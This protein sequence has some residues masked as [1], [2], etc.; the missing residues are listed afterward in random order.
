MNQS[1]SNKARLRGVL[2]PVVTPFNPDFG[3]D[4]GLFIA[5]CKALVADG[6]GLAVF[7]TNSE[8][9]SISPCERMAAL[10]QLLQAGIPADRLMPG[11]GCCSIEETVALTSHA[12]SLGVRSVL[13]LPPF[14]YKEVDQAG[15]LQY[16]GTVIDR[17]GGAS[18]ALYLYNIPQYTQVPITEGLIDALLQHYPECIAG[19]K[20]SSGDWANTSRMLERFAPQGFD[21]FCASEIFLSQTLALGGA[22]CISATANVNARGIRAVIDGAARDAA[23]AESA[24]RSA[25]EIRKVFQSR[26]MISAMKHFLS[27]RYRQP[28]WQTVKPPLSQLKGESKDALIR[29][30]TEIGFS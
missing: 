16:Y 1:N 28:A 13:V 27:L 4:Y 11:T 29:E 18:V 25:T 19:L 14:F 22:G 24:Q 5:H 26:P 6:A 20:D 15:L 30:L 12:I 23:A 8:A 17:L 3:I 10:E 7:G 2:A 21:V 9:A